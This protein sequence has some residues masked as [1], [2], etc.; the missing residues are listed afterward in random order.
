MSTPAKADLRRR[1]AKEDASG[2]GAPPRQTLTVTDNRTGSTYELA[3]TDGTVRALDLRQIKTGEKDFGLM[4][5]DPA[6][7]NTASCRSEIT[8]IDGEAGIL[9]HRG[10]PIEQQIGRAHV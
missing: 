10:Y 6:Y 7:M 4:S 9:Q 5:Y 3:V 2:N 8:Y 1:P